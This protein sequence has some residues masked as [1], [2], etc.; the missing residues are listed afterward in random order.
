MAEIEKEPGFPEAG[1]TVLPIVMNTADQIR[2]DM[3]RYGATPYLLDDGTASQAYDTLGTG[4]HPG[5][6]GHW[7]RWARDG[8]WTCPQSVAH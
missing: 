3:Q 2:P 6:P 5:V 4:M 1:I 7:V 8:S